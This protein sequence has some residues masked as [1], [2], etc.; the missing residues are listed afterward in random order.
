MP[1]GSSAAG[2]I[3]P[4]DLSGLKQAAFVL[5]CIDDGLSES[6]IV[7]LFGRN[8]QLVEGLRYFHLHKNLRERT[9]GM[10]I[11]TTNRG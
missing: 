8:E 3:S 9:E 4:H 10:S 11:V 5:M 1:T 7:A 6:E 2:K